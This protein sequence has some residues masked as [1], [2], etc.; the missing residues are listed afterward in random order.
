LLCKTLS[1]VC[2]GL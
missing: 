2:Y 1:G